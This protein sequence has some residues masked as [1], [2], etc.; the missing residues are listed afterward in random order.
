MF[1]SKG[2][3]R[4]VSGGR[5]EKRRCPECDETTVFRE[6]VVEKTFT[7]YHF[8]D[9][10]SSKS[11]QFC[12]DACGSRLSVDA[13]GGHGDQS[14]IRRKRRRERGVE[15]VVAKLRVG[16]GLDLRCKKSVPHPQAGVTNGEKDVA[17]VRDA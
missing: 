5:F 13:R 6:C 1:G 2:K 11:T 17:G 10:W 4:R 8:V 7:A 16:G 9:L 3:A 15:G 12:Y 14:L